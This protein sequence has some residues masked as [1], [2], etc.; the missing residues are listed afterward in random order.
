MAVEPHRLALSRIMV[1]RRKL[2]PI[3]AVIL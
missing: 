1:F 3:F 2:T